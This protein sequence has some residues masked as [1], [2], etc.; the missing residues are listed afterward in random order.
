MAKKSELYEGQLRLATHPPVL[1][2]TSSITS[3][4]MLMSVSSINCRKRTLVS[5]R[6]KLGFWTRLATLNGDKLLSVGF[7]CTELKVPA[8]IT[9]LMA[10]STQLSLISRKAVRHWFRTSLEALYSELNSSSR[11]T[12]FRGHLFTWKASRKSPWDDIIVD[13]G[14][15]IPCWRAPFLT[16][17]PNAV[18]NLVGSLRLRR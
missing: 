10:Y 5:S 9:L 1:T 18:Q 16:A 2:H 15:G 14:N 6:V 13:S 12:I 7:K 17:R 11:R 4:S 8:A 3:S